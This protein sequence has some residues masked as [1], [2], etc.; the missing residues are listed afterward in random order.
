MYKV[1][2]KLPNE[3][4]SEFPQAGGHLGTAI[5]MY[6]AAM[7][8]EGLHFLAIDDGGGV[9]LFVFRGEDGVSVASPTL[10]QLRDTDPDVKMKNVEA[11][12]ELPWDDEPVK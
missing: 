1:K 7:E 8:N 11:R 3:L 10:P 12:P 9:P 5:E 2:Q 4:L 6:L